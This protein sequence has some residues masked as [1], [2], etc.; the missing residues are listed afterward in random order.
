[1]SAV[2]CGCWCCGKTG[3][4]HLPYVEV[5]SMDAEGAKKFMM[6]DA[7]K[8]ECLGQADPTRH[9]F[10]ARRYRLFQTWAAWEHYLTSREEAQP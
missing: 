6:P 7:V 9:K 5:V 10:G 1:M 4:E 2:H 8:V 3:I